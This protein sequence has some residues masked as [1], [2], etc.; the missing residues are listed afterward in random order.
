MPTPESLGPY[1]IEKTIG[2]GG[3]GTV[4]AA[5]HEETGRRV[6]VK[7]IAH[8]VSDD[9]RFRDR[10]KSEIKSLARLQHRGIVQFMHSHIDEEGQIFYSMELV[11]GE[12]LQSVIRREKRIDWSQ[13]IDIA[14]E[15]CSAL[16]HAHDA[17]VIHR[18]LK[19]ANLM[20][21]GD[22]SIKLVDFGIAKLFGDSQQTKVGS[23]LGTADFMAPEQAHNT[24]ISPRTDLYALGNVMYAMLAGRPPFTGK[25]VTEVIH[26]LKN[27]RVI[28]LD[29]IDPLIPDELVELVHHLLEK[30]PSDRPPT[31]LVVMKRLQSMKAGLRRTNH[32][33]PDDIPTAS[34]DSDPAGDTSTTGSL[35]DPG[36]ST[37]EVDVRGNRPGTVASKAINSPTAATVISRGASRT[38]LPD[39]SPA[40]DEPTR[41]EPVTDFHLDEERKAGAPFGMGDQTAHGWQ[42]WLVVTLMIGVLAIG[43]GL[44]LYA[45][46][47]PSADELYQ[48]AISGDVSSMR[49]FMRR[50]PEDPRFTEIKSLFSETRLEAVLKRLNTQASLGVTPL[51]AAEEG[52]VSAL[53][54]RM[55]QPQAS[56]QKTQQWLN[57]YEG[58][59][60]DDSVFAEMIELAKYE[61]DQLRQRSPE[62]VVDPR[63]QELMDQIDR[64]LQADDPEN[65]ATRLQ[66]IVETFRDSSWAT[67][68]TDRA[69]AELRKLATEDASE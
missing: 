34:P 33:P 45:M 42:H 8:Q 39:G 60:E 63:A 4:Y 27:E 17:G 62:S 69:K 31:A 10:F 40:P 11:E 61:R 49:T 7:L 48:S 66:G 19:P 30:D 35:A 46:Q 55:E 53:N 28:P 13:V 5:I 50:F 12:T 6:A 52:F 54:E 67:P 29:L 16:K 47:P 15:I 58:T 44:F 2:R 36:S 65:A 68:A 14:I 59:A 23:V 18:D 21:T 20:L 32:P 64:I 22:G 56:L 9:Q 51:T 3:M 41:H 26:A 24:N 37:D 43:A 1:R 38:V 57:I 25:K